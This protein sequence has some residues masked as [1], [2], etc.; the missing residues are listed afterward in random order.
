ME[1][2]QEQLIPHDSFKYEPTPYI[3]SDLTQVDQDRMTIYRT[4]VEE[5]EEAGGDAI[6]MDRHF[7]T[8]AQIRAAAIDYGKQRNFAVTTLRSGARQLVLA[9]KHSG[10]YRG[11]KKTAEGSLLNNSHL[12][13]VE[14]E[15][16]P[17]TEE[18]QKR[19]RKKVSRKIQCP[20][21]IRA[22]P[23]KGYWVIYKLDLEHNHAMATDCN[24][25][26]Q[27]R[28]VDKDTRE[29]ILRQMKNGQSNAE[30]VRYL[31]LLGIRNV[32]KKDIANIRQIYLR[33][34]VDD[35]GNTIYEDVPALPA[36]DNSLN[37]NPAPL[38]LMD[39]SPSIP[40]TSPQVVEN[41]E[42]ESEDEPNSPLFLK[43]EPFE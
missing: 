6:E 8:M 3:N 5:G 36:K 10:N 27:H 1:L 39:A 18:K 34:K 9:C 40:N 30:V 23:I 29:I 35:S 7:S 20:F 22:K 15:E 11:T 32:V 16:V 21:Q 41:Q 37:R 4:P 13:T 19:T 2:A 24:A 12:P 38:P 26:S 17:T 31:S 25:Y 42:N 28:R 33:R 43:Q 14:L